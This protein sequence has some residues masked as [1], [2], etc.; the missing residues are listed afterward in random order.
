MMTEKKRWVRNAVATLVREDYA[1][2]LTSAVEDL[3]G[4]LYWAASRSLAEDEDNE[5]HKLDP[6]IDDDVVDEVNRMVAYRLRRIAD[7]LEK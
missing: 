1:E 4:D 3:V 5:K 2:R 7:E 6:Y